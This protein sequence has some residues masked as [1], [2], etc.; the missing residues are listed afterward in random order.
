MK[1]NK[2]YWNTIITKRKWSHK[3]TK[4]NNLHTNMLPL[5]VHKVYKLESVHSNKK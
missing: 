3:G 4:R 5:T 1:G 2:N